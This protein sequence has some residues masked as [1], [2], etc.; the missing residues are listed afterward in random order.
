MKRI[1]PMGAIAPARWA[2]LSSPPV[3]VRAVVVLEITS[4]RRIG[5]GKAPV[6][7]RPAAQSPCFFPSRRAPAAAR[8]SV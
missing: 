2:E 1:E 8:I 7:M 5:C 4:R 6:C 3:L